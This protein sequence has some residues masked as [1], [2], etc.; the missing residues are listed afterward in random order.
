MNAFN[1][2]NLAAACIL[3]STEKAQELGIP[4]DKWIYVLGRAGTSENENFWKRRHFHHSE[5]IRKTIDAALHVSGLSAMDIDCYDFYSCHNTGLVLAN[6][7]MLTYQHAI[8]L[9]A[10]SQGDR[11][12]YAKRN[13]LPTSVDEYSPSFINAGEGPAV[14]EYNR[15]GD[16]VTGLIVARLLGSGQRFIVNHGDEQTLPDSPT[17]RQS[18]GKSG[19]VTVGRDQSPIKMTL[20]LPLT[21]ALRPGPASALCF[22][23]DRL[24]LL[25]S[26]IAASDPPFCSVAS[27]SIAIFGKVWLVFDMEDDSAEP[28]PKARKA[29]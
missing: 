6:G 25:S 28:E 13:P 12:D 22:L 5:A 1:G 8:Y 16:P 9:S 7:G 11:R 17:S 21:W 15:D 20:R 23:L 29:C 18:V 19:H 10:S 14:I 26:A 24:I 3:T 4:E 2:V 27:G